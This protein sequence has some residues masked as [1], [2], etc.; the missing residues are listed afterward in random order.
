MDLNNPTRQDIIDVFDAAH[1]SAQR[2]ARIQE[3]KRWTEAIRDFIQHSDSPATRGAMIAFA[4]TM[5]N[6]EA[7]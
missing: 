2:N 6:G 1:V 3:Q 5:A 4:A 7:P